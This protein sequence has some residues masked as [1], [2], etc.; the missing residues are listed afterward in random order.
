MYDLIKTAKINHKGNLIIKVIAA[1]EIKDAPDGS[2]K[3]QKVT[4]RDNSGDIDF[5]LWNVAVGSLDQGNHYKIDSPFWKEYKDVW[6]PSHGKFT[7]YSLASAEELLPNKD[8]FAEPTE[9]VAP[10]SIPVLESSIDA[11]VGANTLLMIQIE[12]KVRAV[13][14]DVT[15]KNPDNGQVGLYTKMN[16]YLIKEMEAKD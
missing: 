12:H 4:I 15:G 2:W 10:K 11:L 13:L 5:M 1:G 16:F 14:T 7:K 3:N 9:T 8:G 6:G